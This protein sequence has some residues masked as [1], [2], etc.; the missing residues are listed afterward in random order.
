MIARCA[1]VQ[2]LDNGA[3]VTEYTCIH[4]SWEERERT[5]MS[6]IWF[7]RWELSHVRWSID[8]IAMRDR[9]IH[10][11]WKKYVYDYLPTP[12]K[13][14]NGGRILFFLPMHL[15]AN[16]CIDWLEATLCAPTTI[17]WRDWLQLKF[18][19]N[20][21]LEAYRLISFAAFGE[22]V[23]NIDSSSE[24]CDLLITLKV[25]VSRAGDQGESFYCSTDTF[26]R[27][28]R[29]LKVKFVSRLFALK[30]LDLFNYTA[31]T[32]WPEW[33]VKRCSI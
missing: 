27:V 8:T 22:V 4:E 21:A 23:P 9:R 7:N 25:I 14:A 19:P 18:H 10:L 2:S 16:R 31:K 11:D 20:K 29:P 3:H 26:F 6:E 12:T 15:I 13:W 17:L 28:T 24:H 30:S 32:V 1:R 5:E 33:E